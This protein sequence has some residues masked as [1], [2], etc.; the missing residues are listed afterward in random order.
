MIRFEHDPSSGTWDVKVEILI[1]FGSVE[2]GYPQEIGRHTDGAKGHFWNASTIFAKS[3]TSR[4]LTSLVRSSRCSLGTSARVLNKN[5]PAPAPKNLAKHTVK[6]SDQ[7]LVVKQ[8][9][10][11]LL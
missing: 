1:G 10:V 7:R 6:A 2:K 11:K 5:G 8:L 3:S 9:T 4:L